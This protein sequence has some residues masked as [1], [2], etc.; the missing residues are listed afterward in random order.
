MKKYFKPSSK[1]KRSF[2]GEI[3]NRDGTTKTVHLFHASD[4]P[5]RR[6]VKIIGEANPYDPQWETYFEK[7]LD[8]KMEANLRGVKALLYLWKQQNGLPCLQPEKSRR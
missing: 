6:Y 1:R 8:V 7:R 2:F 3:E 5:I 4:V